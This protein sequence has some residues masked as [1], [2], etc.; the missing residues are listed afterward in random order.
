MTEQTPPAG[1][2]D[3]AGRLVYAT[4]VGGLTHL[5]GALR[6]VLG[7][8]IGLMDPEG[9]VLAAS[10][11][12]TFW[13][14]E[15]VASAR[16]GRHPAGT[17]LLVRAIE[18]EGTSVA[19]LVARIREDRHHLL[20][21][22]ADLAAI[23]LSRLL[24]AQQGRRELAAEL[25]ADVLSGSLSEADAA[26]RLRVVGVDPEVP[27]RVL[28]GWTNSEEP[29]SKRLR[30][31]SI[32][33]LMG[34]QQAPF[35]RVHVGRNV[36]MIVPDDV[37]VERLANNLYRQLKELGETA[38]LGVSRPHTGGSGLR[39]AYYEALAATQSGDGVQHPGQL[40]FPRLLALAN[41]ALPLEVIAHQQLQ[42]LIDYDRTHNSELLHTLRTYLALDRDTA[43]TCEALFIHRNTLRYRLKHITEQLRVDIESTAAT[44]SLWLSFLVS[45]PDDP[46]AVEPPRLTRRAAAEHPNEGDGPRD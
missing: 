22:A 5:V 11:V 8:D 25:I 23:E 30:M 33:A 43:A 24:A 35:L 27:F 34:D 14:P 15:L 18:L 20:D 45:A 7:A 16:S 44:T 42:P 2:V 3:A 32:F 41:T 36:L 4:R 1:D 39:A 6:G 13:D 37:A 46:R 40:D 17:E 29:A 38:G 21:V 9:S 19:L 31:D 12:K 28:L 26:G 10:P